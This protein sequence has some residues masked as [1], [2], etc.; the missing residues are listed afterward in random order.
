MKD[1]LT[2]LDRYEEFLEKLETEIARMGGYRIAII[3]TDIKHFKYIND[4][5]GYQ[6]GD[7]LLREFVNRIM[8]DNT[9]TLCA[10]RVYSDNIVL[11]TRIDEGVSNEDVR[12][13]IQQLNLQ[14]EEEFREK[15]MSARLKFC[16]G[17]SI[18]SSDDRRLDPATAVSNANLARKVAKE[19]EDTEVVLFDRKMIEGI[20]REIEIT[21]SLTSAI[22]KGEFIVYYQPKVATG[23]LKL[24]G[25]EALI[26]WK[27]PD[28]TFIYPDD[29]IPL[30]ERSGQIVELDYFV[31]REVFR[32]IAR[33][34]TEGK[35]IVPISVNVS[36]A[37]LNKMGILSYVQELFDEYRIPPHLIEF[38]LTESIYIENTTKALE[39]VE[40]LHAMGTKVS[41]DDFG[42]GY[43]SLN[44]LSRLPIDIIKLD[45]VFL[46][47][48]DIDNKLRENDKIIISC[49][50]DMAKRLQITSLCEGVET[51]EQSDYL[52]EIGCE[53]Q[54]GY[55]FSRPI[56]QEEFEAFMDENF[57]E[58]EMLIAD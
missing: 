54:Q 5:Y 53:I 51:P 43:S 58:Q 37:H 4:T 17:I 44:L 1:V 23:N 49:V 27:K 24:I 14:M 9:H 22:G 52:S 29:F 46:K 41:M 39:L 15:Y 57:Y 25:A 26:R 2:G 11:A 32:F 7:D 34:L 13:F 21:S 28:G 3:Y 35:P 36:R 55:Y 20:K 10:A 33:R 38:E 16:T 30:I 19:M 31:Y 47:D 8:A 50:I 56:P 12:N 40:G 42:S 45:K 48:D 6:A 18:I